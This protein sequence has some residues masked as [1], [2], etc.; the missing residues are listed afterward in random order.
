MT[1]SITFILRL[2]SCVLLAAACLPAQVVQLRD[3]SLL[4]GELQ[5]P[6]GE[7]FTLQR[8]DNGGILR[9]RWEHLTPSSAKVIK[10]SFNLL[11]EA[12]ED[13]TVTADVLEYEAGGRRLR[14]LGRIVRETEDTIVVDTVKGD[15]PVRRSSIRS[16]SRT[17][18]TPYEVYTKEEFYKLQLTR[19][20]PG[21]DANKHLE[22]GDLLM[23]TRD[24]D[25]AKIHMEKARDLPNGNQ[26]QVLE[27]RL[28][29]LQVLIDSAEETGLLAD[30]RRS[31]VTRRFDTARSQIAEFKEKYPSSRLGSELAKLEQRYKKSRD[32]VMVK[33]V[34]A[35]W[36]DRIARKAAL[37]VSE[38][39]TTLAVIKRYAES[40]MGKE[41]RAELAKNLKLEESEV[42]E[43][44]RKRTE[45]RGAARTQQFT[46]S[47]GSWILGEEAVI[48]GTKQGEEAERKK[49]AESEKSAEQKAMEERLKRFREALERQAQAR[50]RS[51]NR[52][53]PRKKEMTPED[54]WQSSG[55]ATRGTKVAFLKALYAEFSGDMEITF[56]SASVCPTCSGS[57]EVASSDTAGNRRVKCGT[58]QG[59]KYRRSIRAR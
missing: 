20:A 42:E 53:Q 11:T 56:A 16:R 9:L 1:K 50:R 41:I 40:D 37:K 47:T 15:L 52:N 51:Q 31:I 57:G 39:N 28:K 48:K 32:L 13:Y 54:W 59:V 22:L 5:D 55:S 21:T 33:R 17:E 34:A 10:T 38:P 12:E 46:F 6:T 8:S 49:A 3:G 29:H 18:V 36:Y 26:G 30:I 44:W 25:R 24:Y 7:G 23:R 35:A 45:V 4:V 27:Q 43:F 19:I 58:C 14:A 2:M